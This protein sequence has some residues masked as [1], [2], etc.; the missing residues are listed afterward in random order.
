MHSLT[1]ELDSTTKPELTKNMTL[2]TPAKMDQIQKI[3]RP[4][5][6]DW[7]CVT[8]SVLCPVCGESCYGFDNLPNYG[9]ANCPH[10]PCKGRITINNYRR[11][12]TP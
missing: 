3:L 2:T 7:L 11:P 6:E 1:K 5:C 4:D 10:D 12:W 8:F 9:T